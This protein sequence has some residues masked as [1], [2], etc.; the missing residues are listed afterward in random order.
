MVKT[1]ASVVDDRESGDYLGVL[2]RQRG[3]MMMVSVS[4]TAV[5]FR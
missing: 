2:V 4:G 5:K 1:T 3:G